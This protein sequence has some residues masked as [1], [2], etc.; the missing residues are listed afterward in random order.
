VSAPP[1]LVSAATRLKRWLFRHALPLWWERGADLRHGGFFERIGMD[2]QPTHAPK[3]L[4]VSARQAHVYALGARLGWDGPADAA[5]RHAIDYVLAR[6]G[7]DGLYRNEASPDAAPLDGMGLIYDQAFVLLALAAARSQL[8]HPGF[9]APALALQQCIADFAHRLGG[10]GE[11]PGLA[12]PLFANPNM[13][14][15]ESFQGWSA[16][17]TDPSWRDLAAMEAKLAMDRLIKPAA[18][19]LGERF[20]PD[21][22]PP[23]ASADRFVW[24]GHLYEWGW[25]LLDW[26]D[27]GSASQAAALRLIEVAERTGVDAAGMTIFALDEHLA[28]TDRGTRLWS[29]TE[30]VRACTRAAAATE[31]DALWLAALEACHALEAFLAVPREG[32]WW[33]WRERTGE[34]REE[35]SPGSSLYHIAGAI[36]E[37]DRTVLA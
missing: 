17:S 34:F 8:G 6:R 32:L 16:I 30:R 3:R 19:T 12:E 28:P 35:A 22:A 18:G 37:L 2:G 33:D 23:A 5:C 9:E 29:Q 13:H 20:G 24:P 7:D 31:D 1:D 21:W 15:F 11:A 36:A 10:Y 4:R 14:L 27:G 26:K 25:L